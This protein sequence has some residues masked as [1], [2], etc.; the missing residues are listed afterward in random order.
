MH[1][2]NA[3]RDALCILSRVLYFRDS[4][5]GGWERER[6]DRWRRSSVYPVH[7]N[8]RR[9]VLRSRCTFRATRLTRGPRLEAESRLSFGT[10]SLL[11]R[12]SLIYSPTCFCRC[13]RFGAFSFRR[14]P[15]LPL[16]M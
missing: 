9:R 7:F 5:M 14:F 11:A 6:G 8:L 10:S 3:F 15:A 4:W 16:R 2:K 13:L 1:R 12:Q